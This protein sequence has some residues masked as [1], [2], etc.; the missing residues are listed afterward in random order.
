MHSETLS[1]FRPIRSHHLKHSSTNTAV[2]QLADFC[3]EMSEVSLKS[4]DSSEKNNKSMSMLGNV[5]EYL[6]SAR[7]TVSNWLGKDE[8]GKNEP[9]LTGIVFT[10]GHALMFGAVKLN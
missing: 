7:E 10:G 8:K 9:S 5:V 2:S 4:V 1:Q 6:K 3:A